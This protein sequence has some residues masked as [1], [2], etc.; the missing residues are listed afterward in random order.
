[1]KKIFLLLFAFV[2]VFSCSKDAELADSTAD[3]TSTLSQ[4]ESN[5]GLY[6]GLFTTEGMERGIVE[7][8]V[9]PGNYAT[10]KINIVDGNII[11]LKSNE[12]VNEGDAIQE[13]RFES[14]ASFSKTAFDL[15][16]DMDGNNVKLS[17]VVYNGV[18]AGMIAAHDT[19]R[20]PVVPITGTLSCDD[21]DAHPLLVT[22]ETGT[23]SLLYVG[24]GSGDDNISAIASV[25]TVITTGGFQNN[26][27]DGGASTT[28]N[29]FGGNI[30]G[31]ND[32]DWIGTHTYLNGTDCSEA[33]GTWE[34]NSVNHGDFT[35]TF[36]S[37][38]NCPTGPT[39]LAYE[40]FEDTTLTYDAADDDLSDI[41][42]RDY[43]G[44]ITPT[45]GLP[46][47]VLYTNIQGNNYYGVQDSDG[48]N[49]PLDEITLTWTDLV[50]TG[51]S[52]IDV[53]AMIAE[54]D[55]GD[56]NEDWDTSSSVRVEYSFNNVDWTIA[57]AF[58]SEL[59]TDGNE[60]N[61]KPREDT[62]FDG[63]GDGAE[64]TPAFTAYSSSFPTGGNFSVSVR[65]YIGFLDAGDED[66]AIDEINITGN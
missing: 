21:C 48:A 18:R 22:G 49:V 2:L 65:V 50:V 14:N 4:N 11:T 23:F 17:N 38:V 29:I 32:I 61:E 57:K 20:A 46:T 7:I 54:D 12:I 6:K 52:T 34:L 66:V 51:L 53:S 55:A 26:C 33:A 36:I 37:D 24:D 63:I 8:T 31:T 5:M 35:G 44:I 10:A 41:G 15:S 25:G 64:L 60:T 40:D 42:S 59:G 9:T 13:L 39:V 43:Y 19:Q 1:M 47:D 3:L 30:I 28:C 16:V 62:D 45:S 56:A 58:E 27:V